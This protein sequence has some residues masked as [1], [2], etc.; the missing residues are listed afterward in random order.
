MNFMV[1]L[2]YMDSALLQ[3]L[4]PILY[5]YYYHLRRTLYGHMRDFALTSKERSLYTDL[6]QQ[7]RDSMMSIHPQGSFLHE[8]VYADYLYEEHKY[9]SALQVLDNY[10]RLN[11]ISEENYE[12]VFAFSGGQIENIARKQIVNSILFPEEGRDLDKIRQACDSEYLNKKQTR[13]I[14]FC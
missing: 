14:G 12:A 3:P 10:A 5:P 11:G 13:P 8:L 7:Y 6:A 1:V 4:D 9:D 2:I